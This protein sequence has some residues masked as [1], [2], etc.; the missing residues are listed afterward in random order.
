[1]KGIIGLRV[2]QTYVAEQGA[3]PGGARYVRLSDHSHLRSSPIDLRWSYISVPVYT[4]S[5]FL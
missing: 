4:V 5:K 1:M 2:K 3:L